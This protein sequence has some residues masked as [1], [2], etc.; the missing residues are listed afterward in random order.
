MKCK[1]FKIATIILLFSNTILA[2][3]VDK[4]YSEKFYT[5]NDVEIAINA[6]NADINVTTWNKNEVEVNAY[7]EIEGLKKEEVEKYFKNW[8]FEALGNKKTVKINATSNNLNF[9]G[10]DNFVLFNNFNQS[11]IYPQILKLNE[12]I[13][14]EVIIIPDAKDFEFKLDDIIIPEI[15]F[16]ELVMPDLE[17]LDFDF[18]KY[19][20]DG[21]KYFFQWKNGAKNI[22]IKSKEEWEKFKKTKEYK[23]YKKQK[24]KR[25]KEL[26]KRLKEL[27]KK[28]IDKEE[29][30]KALETAKIELKKIDKEKIR[31]DIAKAQEVLKNTR[32]NYSFSNEN[33]FIINDKKVKITKRLE[34][35][36]PKNATFKLNTRHCKVKLPKTKAEGK[37]SYG[38]FNADELNGGNLKI[39]SSPVT[40][41]S[42]NAC[43]LFLN[44]VQNA[45]VTYIANTELNSN[46]TDV[47]INEIQKNVTLSNSFGK[48]LVHKINP[49]FQNFIVKL[50]Q[51]DAIINFDKLKEILEFETKNGYLSNFRNTTIKHK[52][53]ET[54]LNGNFT[55]SSKNKENT[56]KINGKFSKLKMQ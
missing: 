54:I 43:T 53:N 42:L 13:N 2:Q 55:V 36:V 5:N 37:V 22:T 38:S 6:S 50:S 14:D 7:I 52:Q 28:K 21:D 45:N 48:V 16:D 10:K 31:R 23:K 56:I 11:N 25:K 9:L 29:L 35:K 46:S 32:F 41:Q 51:S 3:K 24:E 34:V 33:D 30:K 44:N 26:K 8:N 27:K 39:T 17:K 12:N 15:E 4:K 47:T 20:E 40:I 18:D 1:P 19:D 49:N